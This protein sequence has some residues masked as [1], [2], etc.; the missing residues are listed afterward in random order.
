MKAPSTAVSVS[1]LAHVAAIGLLLA[2]RPVPDP[3]PA[4]TVVAVEVSMEP[5]QP[6]GS[7]PNALSGNTPPERPADASAIRFPSLNQ[8]DVGATAPPSDGPGNVDPGHVFDL[9]ARPTF[10]SRPLSPELD[11]LGAML[12]CLTVEGLSRGASKDPHRPYPPCAYADL[13]LRAPVAKLQKD[14]SGSN[15]GALWADEAYRT[16]KTIQPL[17]DESLFP[18][19]VPE[20]NRALKKGFMGLFH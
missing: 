6:S 18:E 1:A 15:E 10:N 14:A 11:R 13:A 7:R 20:A 4:P 2:L 16:F 19:K 17:F 12:D 9:P 3:D 5:E 8:T